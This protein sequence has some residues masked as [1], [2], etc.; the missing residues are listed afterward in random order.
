[1][2][3]LVYRDVAPAPRRGDIGENLVKRLLL[4]CRHYVQRKARRARHGVYR[5][6]RAAVCEQLRDFREYHP[7]RCLQSFYNGLAE[8]LDEVMQVACGEN[9]KIYARYAV[10]LKPDLV[11]SVFYQ[12]CLTHAPR[13]GQRHVA[14]VAQCREQVGCF[15]LAVAKIFRPCISVCKEGVG[16]RPVF[17]VCHVVT[18][19]ALR[20]I[21]NA[22]VVI[23]CGTA[24]H[25]RLNL[26]ILTQI[27][28]T[29]II[30]LHLIICS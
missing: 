11:E 21:R 13:R 23:I 30:L 8:H 27:I 19:F 4:V 1:M 25:L 17:A 22:N 26:L 5:E 16:R 28:R 15:L 3:E 12:S 20:K 2:L 9:V 10:I 6:R 7:A 29:P 14:P 24:K 18:I